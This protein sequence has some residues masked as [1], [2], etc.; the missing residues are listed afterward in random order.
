LRRISVSATVSYS[1]LLL[2]LSPR[3]TDSNGNGTGD[4]CD[5]DIDG[6]G[7]LNEDDLCPDTPSGASVDE[8][9]CS[10]MQ[11]DEDKDGV[12]SPDA[13]SGGLSGCTGTDNCPTVFNPE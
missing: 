12:C 6:D 3:Q 13:P 1:Q 11:V 2:L 9:G 5:T 4:A 7:V 8:V 10:D